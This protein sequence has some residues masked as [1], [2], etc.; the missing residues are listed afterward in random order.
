MIREIVRPKT[1]EI[2]IEIPKEYVNSEV[3][4]LVFNLNELKKYKQPSL[5]KFESIKNNISIVPANV[6]I[7]N[8]ENDINHDIFWYKDSK[9]VIKAYQKCLEVKNCKSINDFIHLEI[10]EKF[11]SKLITYDNG[12]E[13]FQKFYKIDVE[14]LK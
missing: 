4:I 5:Q 1:Q 2:K 13:I 10:A 7:I 6:N 12:F 3:E 8:M 14:I 11:C 9:I